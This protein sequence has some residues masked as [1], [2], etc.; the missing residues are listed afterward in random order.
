VSGAFTFN[1]KD[2]PVPVVQ[3]RLGVSRFL[4]SG[5]CDAPVEQR[6]ELATALCPVVCTKCGVEVAAPGVE[7]IR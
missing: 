1:T 5:C 4:L 7:D 3:A 6:Y 2:F